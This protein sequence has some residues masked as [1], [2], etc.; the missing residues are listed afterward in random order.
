MCE[1]LDFN[2]L[3]LDGIN[4][5]RDLPCVAVRAIRAEHVDGLALLP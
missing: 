1:L 4:Q 3:A 5:S 2:E